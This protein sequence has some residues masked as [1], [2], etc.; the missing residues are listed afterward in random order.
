[1]LSHLV[2]ALGAALALPLNAM[3][4]ASA[5]SQATAD[6]VA[7]VRRA[8]IDRPAAQ[9]W[10]RA[11]GFCAVAKWLPVSCA[12]QS[13]SGGLGSIRLING[14]ILEVMVANSPDSYSYWQIKGPM[15]ASGYHG[16]VAIVPD[17]PRKSTVIYTLVYN[18]NAFSTPAER[19]AQRERLTKRFQGACDAI[20]KIAEVQP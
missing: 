5:A 11:G 2:I 12:L 17:G 18:Q 6:F 4:P 10:R 1:M 7:I 16:T 14:S 8:E 3:P 15:A 9:A 20:R 13:G 19:S